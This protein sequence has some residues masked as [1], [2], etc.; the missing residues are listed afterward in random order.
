MNF[1]FVMHDGQKLLVD[2][3]NDGEQQAT[4]DINSGERWFKVCKMVV[5]LPL[6]IKWIKQFRE[7]N[8]VGFTTC[9]P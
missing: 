4:R 7:K 5:M 1:E 2:D 3:H 8:W 9:L 6:V